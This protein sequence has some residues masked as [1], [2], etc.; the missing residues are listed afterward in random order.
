MA[1]NLV[2]VFPVP[3]A[4]SKI[5]QKLRSCQL[6]IAFFWYSYKLISSGNWT[7]L[8]FF[9][10]LNESN[11]ALSISKSGDLRLYFSMISYLSSGKS[12]ISIFCSKL[13]H[14]AENAVWDSFMEPENITTL[15][16]IIPIFS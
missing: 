9:S 8:S 12:M 11:S 1:A 15:S 7:Y 14:I 5:S 6:F 10:G 4:I 13:C 16:S 2:Y 3:V